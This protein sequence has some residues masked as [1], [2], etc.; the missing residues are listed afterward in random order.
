MTNVARWMICGALL[1][2]GCVE[3]PP[4]RRGGQGVSAQEIEA[5]RRRVVTNTAPN[6]QHRLDFNF[7]NKVTLLGYDIS[8]AEVR[9]GTNVTI[10]WYWRA[11]A[12]TGDGWR[13]YTHLDDA[14]GPRQNHDSDGDV[15]RAY[16]PERW[17]RGEFITDRQSFEIPADWESPVIKIHVG[18]WKGDERMP[19]VRGQTSPDGR[20]LALTINTGVQVRV[21][22]MD[23][24]RATGAINIDGRLDEPAWRT[25][26]TTGPLVNP[27]SGAPAG[28]TDAHGTVRVLWDDQNLYLGWEVTDDNLVET[29][30]T[31]DAHYWDNDT[32]E[33]MIDPDGDGRNYYELQVSPGNHTFDTQHATPRTPPPFGNVGWNPNVRSA[34]VANGT[35]GNPADNDTGYTVEM[36]IPWTDINAGAP[37]TPPQVGDA[38][39]I[40]FFLMDK[41]KDGGSRSAAWS[42]PRTGDFHATDRFGRITFRGPAAAAP[43]GPAAEVGPGAPVPSGLLP[44]VAHPNAVNLAPVGANAAARPGAGAAPRPTV[45]PAAP[46]PNP[47]AH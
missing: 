12:S 7:G 9:P 33:V 43:A 35:L 27:Q 40:N 1:A 28:A 5:V 45:G 19:V 44:T 24:P 3:Q 11:D 15:R 2:A 14:N 32:T 21:S 18:L 13:L 8:P 4:Q 6:P 39:R 20:A 37:H 31:R 46:R 22:E 38:W 10:T 17:R 25:A 41:A 30:T 29:G 26:G 34:V 47:G 23:A 36:A 16:Q 42:P